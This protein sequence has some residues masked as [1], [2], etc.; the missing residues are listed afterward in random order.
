MKTDGSILVLQNS[1]IFA[2]NFW[3]HD[4][5]DGFEVFTYVS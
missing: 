5:I 3:L 1:G 2:R 4:E